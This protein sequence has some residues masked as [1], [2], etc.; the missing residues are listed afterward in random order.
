[1]AVDSPLAG[2][3]R[4]RRCRSADLTVQA[5]TARLAFRLHA[6]QWPQVWPDQQSL[7]PCEPRN[8]RKQTGDPVPPS[9][10]TQALEKMSK[11]W[12]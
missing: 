11:G 10:I 5:G 12:L 8:T 9:C 1:M 6:E 3:P 7:L 2:S 4:T